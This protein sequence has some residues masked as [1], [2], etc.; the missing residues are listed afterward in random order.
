LNLETEAFPLPIFKPYG[1]KAYFEKG[2]IDY[3]L[4]AVCENYQLQTGNEAILRNIKIKERKFS[5]RK[6]IGLSADRISEH[7]N[8]K[9]GGFG[10]RFKTQDS[11]HREMQEVFLKLVLAMADECQKAM[12]AQAGDTMKSNLKGILF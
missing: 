3:L 11:M 5:F 1:E 7:I 6:L 12:K 2:E 4:H 9:Q 8:E 10:V